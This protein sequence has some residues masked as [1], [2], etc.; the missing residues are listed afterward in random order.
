MLGRA[1]NRSLSRVGRAAAV[2]ARGVTAMGR[3]AHVVV[4][5][6]KNQVGGDVCDVGP[7]AIDAAGLKRLDSPF[8][9]PGYVFLST[10]FTGDDLR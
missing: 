6:K 5:T 4:V 8:R 1:M 10:R 2:P 3:N 7:G 9:V